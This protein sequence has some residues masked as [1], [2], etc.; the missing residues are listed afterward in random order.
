MDD[1]ILYY[2]Y[3]KSCGSIY[4]NS[5]WVILTA[6]YVM[7][8]TF[9]VDLRRS[10]DSSTQ[11]QDGNNNLITGRSSEYDHTNNTNLSRPHSG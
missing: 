9:N 8:L 7:T 3:S 1:I 6:Y 4:C 10:N 11:V 2:T 5:P